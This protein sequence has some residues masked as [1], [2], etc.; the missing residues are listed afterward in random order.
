MAKLRGIKSS[1]LALVLD[2]LGGRV[3]LLLS[4]LATTTQAKHQMESGLLLDVV[5]RKRTTVLK[6]LACKDQALLIW[7]DSFLVL[8]YR[9]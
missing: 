9:N 4:F 2:L 1:L 3:D 6:L 7:G 8:C 5:V